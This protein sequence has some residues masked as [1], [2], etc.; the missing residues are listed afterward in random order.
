M[1]G[2]DM[3]GEFSLTSTPSPW[4][5]DGGGGEEAPA[6]DSIEWTAEAAALRRMYALEAATL[7]GEWEA[8]TAEAN[9]R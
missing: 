6:E 7:S 8:L 4:E 1:N 3:I 9:A 2:G 5:M